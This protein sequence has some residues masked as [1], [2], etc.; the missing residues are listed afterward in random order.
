MQG[1]KLRI[2]KPRRIMTIGT[3]IKENEEQKEK[4]EEIPGLSQ[5]EYVVLSRI[6]K[7]I[8]MYEQK[9]PDGKLELAPEK[10]EE[11]PYSSGTVQKL[12]LKK[13]NYLVQGGLFKMTTFLQKGCISSIKKLSVFVPETNGEVE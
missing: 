2:G 4:S 13:L 3:G 8:R 12:S 6:L 1:Y 9:I 5:E 10:D 11:Q 7:W